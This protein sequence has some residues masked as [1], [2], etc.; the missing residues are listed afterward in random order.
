LGTL[1]FK[2]GALVMRGR[3]IESG[4]VRDAHSVQ[5]DWN[6]NATID[7][8]VRFVNHVCNEANVGIQKNDVGAYDFHAL[9]GIGALTSRKRKGRD[10][11]PVSTSTS[12]KSSK[13]ITLLSHQKE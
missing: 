7:L 1:W 8:P 2:A 6:I 11:A 3:A 9:H 10:S 12:R 4:P 5:T 13:V